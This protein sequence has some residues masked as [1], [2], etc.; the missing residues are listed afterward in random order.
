M[1]KSGLEAGAVGLVLSYAVTLLGNFQWT[2]RQSA[3]MEN[4]VRSRQ[5]PNSGIVHPSA[6]QAL[7]QYVKDFYLGMNIHRE[8]N[9]TQRSAEIRFIGI[10]GF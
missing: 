10:K 3:E 7:L 6:P 8:N 5:S 2:I 4:M 1:F 9:Q